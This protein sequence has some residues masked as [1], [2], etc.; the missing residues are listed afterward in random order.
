MN[1]KLSN[2]LR[3]ETIACD[4]AGEA[5]FN[6]GFNLNDDPTN[7]M[8]IV[9]MVQTSLNIFKKSFVVQRN[10]ISRNLFWLFSLCFDLIL[11]TSAR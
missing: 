7:L 11:M 6:C 9:T 10:R 4:K 8:F 2:V 3:I 5:D 1:N